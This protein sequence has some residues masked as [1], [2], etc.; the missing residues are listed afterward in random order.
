LTDLSPRLFSVALLLGITVTGAALASGPGPAEL[1]DS[2][3]VPLETIDVSPVAPESVRVAVERGDLGHA[4]KLVRHQL[5][6]E[7]PEED[8]AALRLLEARLLIAQDEFFSGRL[9]YRRLLADPFVGETARAELHALYVGRGEFAA[10]EA[11]TDVE[12]TEPRDPAANLR[13]RAYAAITRGNYAEAL[14]LASSPLLVEDSAA[15]VMRGNAQLV[16]GDLRAAEYAFLGVLERDPEREF[17]QAAHFG[18]AQVAR[19]R[20]ARAVRALEDERAVRF[21]PA[22]WAELD[23]GLALRALGRRDEAR[24][25]LEAVVRSAPG[26]AGTAR[27]AL[28]RLDEEQGHVDDALEHLV[29]GL[30]GSFGDFIALTRLGDLL[31]QEGR[32]EPAVEAY[33]EALAIF[34]AFP[35]AREALGRLLTAQGRWE[36]A[37]LAENGERTWELP[38]WTWDRLLDGDLPFYE[39]AAD[40]D[41]IPPE[42][43][44]RLVI[45]LVHLRAAS[46]PAALGWTEDV[47]LE[48]PELLE[49]RAEALEQVGR[50][51][52][53]RTL[54]EDLLRAQV[55]SETAKE[56]LARLVYEDD[57]DRATVLWGE[58]VAASATPARLRMR[59]AIV[60][61]EAGELAPALAEARAAREGGW[62]STGEKRRLR[63]LIEDL[64]DMQ[65][66]QEETE[67]S[68]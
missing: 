61:E 4:L 13:M 48:H 52:D 32:Q 10:A 1:P 12:G 22:A 43:A 67:S 33:R 35:R 11:L 36:E 30:A 63:I 9:S 65:R 55:A 54:L 7:L 5:T 56:R 18:L 19:R 16:I 6:F 60:L 39:I 47:G 8:A 40:R 26:L 51:E 66:E 53:A 44:R 68:P 46:A 17:R 23:W 57:P 59:V 50:T 34:P 38:G 14:R 15:G 24:E 28:A 41:S 58:L 21:G 49:V 31:S 29:S 27:L 37:S 42:D 20:G 25:K 45:A 2:S 62:L 3:G 64:E